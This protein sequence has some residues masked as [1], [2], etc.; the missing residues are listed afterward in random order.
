MGSEFG[1]VVP[2]LIDAKFTVGSDPL[3]SIR[4]A[5][6]K[7]TAGGGGADEFYLELAAGGDPGLTEPN[8]VL[9]NGTPMT[10]GSADTLSAG[11]WDWADSDTLG[12]STIYV[13]LTATG[14]PDAQAVDFVQKSDVDA[15]NVAVQ[16][17][18]RLNGNLMADE[19]TVLWYLSTDVTGQ[20]LASAPSGG[21]A[22]G[23]DGLLIE[24]TANVAG[25]ATSEVDGDLD[26]N[27][28]ET[29]QGNFYLN[30]IMPDGK[31]MVSTVID[32]N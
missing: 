25:I 16:F 10:A 7:W 12:F 24:W 17:V 1:N 21:I 3:T 8:N 6:Y 19:V 32:F 14:D 23:T 15:I 2:L 27:L 29:G 26:V 5:T 22:I 30:L 4:N 18:D 9:E 20:V 28:T 13:R 11:E 31:R